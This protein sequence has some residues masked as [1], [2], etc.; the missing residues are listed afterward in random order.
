MPLRVLDSPWD[1][2]SLSR[3]LTSL[4]NEKYTAKPC[5]FLGTGG[6]IR[7]CEGECRQIYSL[8]CLT[9]PQPQ[10]IHYKATMFITLSWSRFSDSNRRPAVYKTAALTN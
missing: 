3:A 4:R 6:R 2:L 7:T 9:A 1:L 8:L 5:I 10:H